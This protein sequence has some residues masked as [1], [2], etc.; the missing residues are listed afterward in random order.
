M[1][2]CFDEI[3]DRRNTD[4]IKWDHIPGN[5]DA[6]PMWVADMDFRCPQPVI[7]RVMEKAAFGVYAY[8]ATP[9]AFREATASWQRRRHH[10]DMGEATVIPVS[11]VVPALYTAVAAF[12]EP[13]DRVILQRPVYGPFT[14]AV[15]QQGREISNNALL[16]QNGH[17]EVDF[18]DLERRAADPRAKLMLLCSPHNPVGKVFTRQ[19]LEKIGEICRRNHVLLFADE[20][21]GDFVYPGSCHIPAASILTDCLVA[22]APSI[23]FNLASM[24]AAAVISPNPDLAKRFQQVLS[25]SHGDNMNMLGLYAYIAA[26]EKGDEYLEQLLTYLAGNVAHLQ[27][28]LAEQLPQIR[29]IA[30]QGTYLMWL[31]CRAMGMAQNELAD[32]FTWKAGV[33]MNT[34]EWFGPEGTGFMRMNLACPRKT[35]D[36]ALDRI[37]GAFAK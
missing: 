16:L 36:L 14:D 20:I 9:P 33:A 10:W 29:L 3:I 31:D 5:P 8:T 34:G 15:T 13:G 35:L 23:T 1:K 2:Y 30:P 19:E 6:I 11:S 7:D 18:E 32:F 26:Y 24:K 21:H 27:K 22:V 17:Y 12:T 4:S 28:R 37:A 25:L